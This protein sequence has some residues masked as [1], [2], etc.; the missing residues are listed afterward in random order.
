MRKLFIK[1]AI[2]IIFLI[3]GS[4]ILLAQ[5]KTTQESSFKITIELK[6]DVIKLT[7][8]NGCA[9]KELTFQLKK[10]ET[11]IIDQFGMVSKTRNATT[12]DKNLAI[13]QFSIRRTAQG[14]SLK[15]SRGPSMN[16]FSL[17]TSMT[18]NSSI[19]LDQNGITSSGLNVKFKN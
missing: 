8:E 7:G 10:N 2:L 14:I 17:S 16:D 15:G 1:T 12:Q 4:C 19:I 3:S 13:F 5:N 9:W 18:N 6:D 11:Q